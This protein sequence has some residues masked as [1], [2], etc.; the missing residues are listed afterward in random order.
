MLKR[1]AVIAFQTIHSPQRGRVEESGG[2]ICFV[3]I[4]ERADGP[5]ALERIAREHFHRPLGRSV[6]VGIASLDE[7]LL[8]GICH[9]SG[10]VYWHGGDS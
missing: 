2:G 5:L 8:G 10:D 6:E 9:R 3:P 7:A 1:F 4:D